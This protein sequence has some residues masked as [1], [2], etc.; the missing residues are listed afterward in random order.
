MWPGGNLE[1]GEP[2]TCR[3]AIPDCERSNVHARQILIDSTNYK[4]CTLC[5]EGKHDNLVAKSNKHMKLY[6]I[7]WFFTR[8]GAGPGLE[9]LNE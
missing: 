3:V 2:T 5:F 8:R 4:Y 9:V 6:E 7:D 1:R